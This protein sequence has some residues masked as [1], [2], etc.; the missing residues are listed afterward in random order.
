VDLGF[1]RVCNAKQLQD[2]VR[3]F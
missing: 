1:G 2:G 3:N